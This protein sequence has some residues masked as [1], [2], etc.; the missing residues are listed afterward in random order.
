MK[1]IIKS[2]V[3]HK[4][5]IVVTTMSNV[6]RIYQFTDQ[7]IKLNYYNDLIREMN[8]DNMSWHYVVSSCHDK[9]SSRYTSQ[10]KFITK[11]TIYFYK[12]NTNTFG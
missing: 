7:Q 2:V 10:C 3:L 8:Y 11:Q 1:R 4:Y 6:K 5:S 12:L 9:E